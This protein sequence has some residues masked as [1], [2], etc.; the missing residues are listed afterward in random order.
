MSERRAWIVS[1]LGWCVLITITV[2]LLVENLD[3]YHNH[4]GGDYSLSGPTMNWAH[5]WPLG[6]MARHSCKPNVASPWPSYSRWPIDGAPAILVSW[7]FLA[8]DLL[9]AV[10]IIGGTA[11]AIRRWLRRWGN[12]PVFSIKATLLLF[13]IVVVATVYLQGLVQRDQRLLGER[14]Q[15]ASS[16]KIYSAED[17]TSLPL[18][19]HTHYIVQGL[20]VVGVGL[21]VIGWLSLIWGALSRVRGVATARIAM[22]ADAE[23]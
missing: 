7:K 12:R 15:M 6:F 22:I 10:S 4:L 3:G 16:N 14:I 11:V 5:G 9:V 23:S 21:A 1:G 2:A 19:F 20:I 17:L 13:A 18:R 8:I